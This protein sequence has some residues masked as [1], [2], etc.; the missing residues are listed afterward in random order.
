MKKYFLAFLAI[1]GSLFAFASAYADDVT[2]MIAATSSGAVDKATTL[3]S[4]P[5]GVFIYVMLWL[6][7]VVAIVR[8]VLWMIS[9]IKK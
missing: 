3:M 5:V 4:G 9:M 8:L 6:A 7:F 1:F 2:D